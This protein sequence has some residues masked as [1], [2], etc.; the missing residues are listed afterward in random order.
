[1]PI[2]EAIC[3]LSATARIASPMRVCRNNQVKI[4][5]KIRLTTAP[6]MS[7]GGSMMGPRKKG[8]CWIGISSARVPAPNSST[9]TP[10]SREATPMVAMITAMIG[11]PSNGRSTTR[12]R[13]KQNA[14][15]PTTDTMV[16]SQN[17]MTV[18]AAAAMKPPVMTNSPWAKL[19][20]S[21]AL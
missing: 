14:T 2:A 1:M 11:R 8:V 9:T 21:V 7:I 15:R 5:K 18:T 17:G 10:R 13:P 6:T 20:A 19:N 4:P 16:A 3:W 12:S